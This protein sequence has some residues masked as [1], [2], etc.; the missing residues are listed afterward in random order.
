M[1][2]EKYTT[3]EEKDVIWL[4]RKIKKYFSKIKLSRWQF[5]WWVEWYKTKLHLSCN[6]C[7][8]EWESVSIQDFLKMRGCSCPKCKITGFSIERPTYVYLVRIINLETDTQFSGYGITCNPKRIVKI[9]ISTSLI[10]LYR[11]WWAEN[12]LWKLRKWS[13]LRSNL[14]NVIY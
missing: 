14:L 9:K 11:L 8:T 7:G 13:V 10:Y 2:K 1:P 3:M 6:K 5:C 4:Y 12:L